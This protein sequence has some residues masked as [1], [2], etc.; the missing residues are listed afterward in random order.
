MSQ[1]AS[2]SGRGP[3]HEEVTSW[4][5]IGRVSMSP[6]TQQLGWSGHGPN[7]VLGVSVSGPGF[8]LT[9]NSK[10]FKQMRNM[11][12]LVFWVMTLVI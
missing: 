11:T 7:L 8:R 6:E 2:A 1:S 12:G 4:L 9:R 5:F 10:G 3:T